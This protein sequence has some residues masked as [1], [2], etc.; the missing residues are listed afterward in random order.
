MDFEWDEAKADGN[1]AKHGIDFG[2]ATEVFDDPE[3][4]IAIDPRSYG[5][6]AVSG[7]RHRSRKTAS[8]RLYNAWRCVPHHQCKEGEL[9]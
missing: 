7:G 8:G 1:R 4:L 9:P 6:G 5:E 3:R 2:V